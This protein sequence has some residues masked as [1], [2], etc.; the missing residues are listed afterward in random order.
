MSLTLTISYGQ[1]LVQ[2][3]V[4]DVSTKEP[5]AFANLNVKNSGT[6]IICD[7]NGKF[8]F[9]DNSDI[10]NI[11][12][13]YVG[14]QKKE[15]KIDIKKRA[16]VIV[17]LEPFLNNLN[18][19]V[20][21]PSENPANE[22][23][24]KVIANKKR[25][26][27][28]NLNSFRYT[29]YNKLVYDY[30]S[31][32]ED[33]TD[34]ISLREKLK[35]SH[36]FMMESVTERKFASPDLSEEVVKATKVSGFKNPTFATIATDFQPFSFYHDNIKFFNI[37]YLNPIAN[38]SLTKYRFN[39][40]DIVISPSDTTYVV[41]FKPRKNK[42][43]DGLQGLLYIN[44]R[45]YAIQNVI[46]STAEKG[47]IAIKIQQKYSFIDDKFW[48]PEQLNFV[49]RFNDFPNQAN[50]MTVNGKTYLSNVEINKLQKKEKFSFQSV[51]LAEEATSKEATFW[52]KYR[53]EAMDKV[54]VTTYRVLDSIGE[55]ENFDSY[56]TIVEKL[57]QRRYP[58]K[59]V[60]VDLSKIL[61]Y[62]K[63][64][65]LRVGVGF[66]T[67][68]DISKKI[69]I[70][71]FVGYGLEDKEYKYGGRLDFILSKA[72]E[73]KIG[74]QYQNNLMEAG[75]DYANLYGTDLFNFREFI[76]YRYDQ[77]KQFGFSTQFRSFKYLLCDLK[78][79]RTE[80]MPKYE[81]I[82]NNFSQ[83]TSSYINTNVTVNLRFGYKE[84]FI[85]S[86][87]QN[88]TS[89]SKYPVFFV[90]IAKGFKD[91]S[92]GYFNYNKVE[93]AIE[94]SFFTKNFGLTRYRTEAGYIDRSLPYGLLFTGEGGYDKD[95]LFIVKNTFQT[96]MAYEFLSDKYLNLFLTHNFGGLLFKKNKF[97]P[98]IIIHHNLSWGTLS[99]E[100]NH[101]QI[102]FKVKDKIFVESGLQLDN[103]V[104][105]NYLNLADIGF[106]TAAF[107]RYGYYG[108]SNFKDNIFFKFT[109]NISI[110]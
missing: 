88:I 108:Y 33:K 6:Q 57:M 74:L 12:C 11:I 85:N 14:Y 1:G 66:S 7:I 45:H 56:L 73:F 100:V 69:S 5:L 91:F 99:N 54:D 18:E 95:M 2:G 43:F 94:Q 53:V 75:R 64:E 15:F 39:L 82:F 25:N 9:T 68:E 4:V 32:N 87:N 20:I 78:L 101:Q 46:A 24:R 34:S 50:P 36:F 76:G 70:G 49:I 83:S 40:E 13:S 10:I 77:I 61:S 26:N 37:N 17:E 65:G 52:E 16:N 86:F 81:Y 90:S 109:L 19:V 97:Q 27:P 23:I 104:K 63:Y 93:A 80:R 67:N 59:Y 103:L 28:E 58:L 38:Q 55:K 30:Q 110:K 35:G 62:N 31:L 60:D 105:F 3:T 21:D 92:A 29:S 89:G 106:G 22:I 98:N 42:N 41:S 96:M 102:D 48:F 84:H 51:R 44:S 8:S 107:Y 71:N 72:Q 79:Q 47:R